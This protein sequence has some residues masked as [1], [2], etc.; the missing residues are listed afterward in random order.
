MKKKELR[1]S[2]IKK[3]NGIA[4]GFY[5]LELPNTW[6]LIA[7]VR[8]AKDVSEKVYQQLIAHIS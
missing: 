8:K 7:Y 3:D 5:G 2:F 1:I 6:Y 4:E